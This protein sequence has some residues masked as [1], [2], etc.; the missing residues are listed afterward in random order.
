MKNI[1]KK[2]LINLSNCISIYRGFTDK[3][4]PSASYF[5]RCQNVI[6]M[7]HNTNISSQNNTVLLLLDDFR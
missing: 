5:N 4:S 2:V 1:Q 7:L 3:H 6:I